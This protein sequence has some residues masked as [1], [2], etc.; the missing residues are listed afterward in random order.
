MS[1]DTTN[2]LVTTNGGFYATPVAAGVAGNT[3]V[4]I[5]PSRVC[6]VLVTVLGTNP[7]TIFDNGSGAASGTI[8]GAIPAS[9]PVGTVYAFELFCNLGILVQ[10]NAANP[11]ITIGW[12]A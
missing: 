3:Q 7:L 6:K 5:G 11:G 10:G 8:V 4:K 1:N 9:A 12:A 2:E